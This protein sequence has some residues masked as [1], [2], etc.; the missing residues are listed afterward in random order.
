M[1]FKIVTDSAADI[2]SLADVPFDS[3]PLKIMT[4]A[5]EYVDNED[6]DVV[7]MLADLK[8]YKG[9]S[10]SMFSPLAMLKMF[11]ALLLQAIFRVATTPL[12][13]LQEAIWRSIPAEMYI[14]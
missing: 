3:V 14:S 6:L 8:V 1:K 9:R 5:K 2:K 12:A 7:G 4:D 11:S 10:H 13:L